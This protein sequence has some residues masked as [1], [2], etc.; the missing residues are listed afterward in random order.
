MAKP[1]RTLVTLC[2]Y[3][4]SGIV[5][6]VALL[7]ILMILSLPGSPRELAHPLPLAPG[8]VLKIEDTV[9]PAQI[10]K[11][12][13]VSSH[14]GWHGD[15][16][17]ITAYRIR[18]DIATAVSALEGMTP[19]LGWSERLARDTP[20]TEFDRLFPEEFR[21]QH[22]DRLRFGA[23]APRARSREYYINVRRATVYV[24]EHTF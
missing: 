11:A 14:G 12:F 23:E 8:F 4:S 21:P 7:W 16:I 18:F 9:L 10:E 6:V 3:F 19:A 17:D 22:N 2:I 13:F 5:V 15:G 1:R 20:I 24:V